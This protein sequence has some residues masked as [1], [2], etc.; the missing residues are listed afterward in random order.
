MRQEFGRRYIEDEFTRTG[1]RLDEPLTVYL[2]G[3]GALA[4]RDLKDATKDIDVVVK[5]VEGLTRLEEALR[6][7]DYEPVRDSGEEYEALGATVILENNDGCRVDIFNQQ[8]V[9]KLIFSSGMRARSQQ[10]VSRGNLIVRTASLEDMF[11]FK[12]VAG[13]A[14]DIDDMNTL[15]QSGLDFD[16]VLDELQRQIELLDEELFV[17]YVNEALIDLA[18]RF[19]V[20]TPLKEDVE[21]I[22]KRVYDELAILNSL[23]GATRVEEIQE[24][25]EL[26]EARIHEVLIGLEEKGT[27]NQLGTRVQ[28]VDDNA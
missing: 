2:I 9:G 6:Q 3:G 15:V 20:T 18:D 11:L 28:K 26:P 4:F 10:L 25:T 19:G 5:D 22:T 12:S 17:T 14:G 1:N 13:R 24:E 8:V 16:T 7:L 21:E 23:D 27:I